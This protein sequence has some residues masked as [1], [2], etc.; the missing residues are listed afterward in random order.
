MYLLYSH[1]KEIPSY[2]HISSILSFL[3]V[4][5]A[6]AAAAAAGFAKFAGSLASCES[7]LPS[8]SRGVKLGVEPQTCPKPEEFH[9]LNLFYLS[10]FPP[11]LSS[12]WPQTTPYYHIPAAADR[13]KRDLKKKGI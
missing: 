12:T 10:P 9:Y 11:S 8:N 5:A 6:A 1:M 3:V 7:L 4:A 2:Y 13:P